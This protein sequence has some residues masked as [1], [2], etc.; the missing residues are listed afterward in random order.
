M[1]WSVKLREQTISI[2]HFNRPLQLPRRR[3]SRLWYQNGCSTFFV[4]ASNYKPSTMWIL[5]KISA[6]CQGVVQEVICRPPSTGVAAWS[7]P[8]RVYFLVD[9]V[10]VG[11]SFSSPR[12]RVFRMPPP[13]IFIP[14][15]VPNHTQFTWHRK[16][17]VPFNFIHR[18]F[19]ACAT[20]SKFGCARSIFKGIL[21]WEQCDSYYLDYNARDFDETSYAALC[22]HVLETM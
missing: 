20:N 18:T 13:P 8:V 19:H 17:R 7:K 4:L 21:L 9:K 3:G 11:H 12:T 15:V 2:D 14:P 1:F 5:I 22:T 6:S 10:T 16:R